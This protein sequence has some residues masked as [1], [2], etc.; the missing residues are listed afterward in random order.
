[1]T[2]RERI[3]ALLRREPT[4]R[5]PISTYELSVFGPWGWPK[6]EPSYQPLM[7]EITA[8]TDAFALWGAYTPPSP[9]DVPTESETR[10]EG[11]FTVTRTT[12]HTP[13][14]PLSTTSKFTPNVK[15][16]WTVEHLCKDE[17]D[18]E[19]YLSIPF[20]PMPVDA[21]EFPALDAEVGDRGIVLCDT[22]DAIGYVAPLFEF[23]E[24]TVMAMTRPALIRALCDQAHERIMHTLRGMLAA[25]CGPLYRIWGPEYCTPP[26]LPPDAFQEFVV[27][28]V[29]EMIAL[30]HDYG[31]WARIHS[32][33]HTRRVLDMMVATGADAIDPVEPPPDGDIPLGEVKGRY[34]DR[35]ILFGNMELKYLETETPAE[36][37]ARVKVMMNE[38]KAGGGY[39]LM[40]TAGPLN[41]PL[42]PRTADNYRAFIEAGHKYG[43]Y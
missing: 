8:R 42:A 31:C 29:T 10:Q 6:D 3:L 22:G 38:A 34:G 18:A 7:A 24:F 11:E 16:T 37:D 4:D 33:G 17:A 5:V 41:I 30:I 14:G 23:G 28:Y 35:L 43:Q 20:H 2:G 19:R 39:V 15:T 1:M 12:L 25:G 40:P 36:I 32:H 21:A 9:G 27:P 26:Y 13:T